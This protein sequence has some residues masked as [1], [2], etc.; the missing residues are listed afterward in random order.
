MRSF[1]KGIPDL[2]HVAAIAGRLDLSREASARRYIELREDTLALVLSK[3]GLVRYVDRSDAFPFIGL[4]KNDTMPSVPDARTSDPITDHDEADP[5]D[6]GMH[7]N[8]AGLVV[9]T[10]HQKNS[11]AITL[12]ALDHENSET[13]DA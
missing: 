10:L 7:S 6:W 8:N 4:R 11:F 1:L 12:L 13:D 3:A 9:Q 5:R 2:G